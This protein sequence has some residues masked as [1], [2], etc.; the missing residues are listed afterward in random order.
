M[1]ENNLIKYEGGLVKHVGNA[2][3]ITNKLLSLNERKIIV[4]LFVSHP[5]FFKTRISKIYPLNIFLIEKYKDLW[6]WGGIGSNKNI[7][8]NGDFI[9]KYKNKWNWESLGIG[10]NI[11]L[12]QGLIEKYKTFKDIFKGLSKNENITWSEKFIS[13][14]SDQWNWND[15]GGNES[16]DWTEEFVEINFKRTELWKGLSRNKKFFCSIDFIKKY[17]ESWNWESLTA[18]SDINRSDLLISSYSNKNGFWDGIS[19]NTG[20]IW[21]DDLI[22][23]YKSYW[24]WDYLGSNP[25]INWSDHLIEKYQ[26]IPS[27]WKCLTGGG[28]GLSNNESIIWSEELIEKY[29]DKL[30]WFHLGYNERLPWSKS[31]FEKYHERWS[32]FA[33]CMN[34]KLDWTEAFI[35]KYESSMNWGW[36]GMNDSLPWSASFIKKY[37][38][39][40]RYS[41]LFANTLMLNFWQKALLP[42]MDDNLIE[43]VIEKSGK[44]K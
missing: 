38:S 35:E 24:R 32:W 17:H 33:L 25:S 15:L 18:N 14:Y 19:R 11:R 34:R 4:D 29:K 21:T 6:D 27:L 30:S 12:S 7:N 36:L 20:I 41:G 9:D 2:I 43:E 28:S 31:F 44:S 16:I 37:E 40:W 3:T 22:E 26:D 1:E 42:Y 5:G 13:N 10:K 23:K 39:K 8:L